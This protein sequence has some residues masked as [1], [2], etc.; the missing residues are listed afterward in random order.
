MFHIFYTTLFV[1]SFVLFVLLVSFFRERISIYYVLLFASILV[2]N[3]GYMQFCNAKDIGMAIYAN[4]TVYLGACFCPFFLMKCMADLC[5]MKVP[6]AFSM[7]LIFYSSIIFFFTMTIGESTLYY[8]N[9]TFVRQNGFSTLIKEY[10]PL[11]IL[12]PIYLIGVIEI[13]LFFIIRSFR[14]RKD[15]SYFTSVLLLISTGL[16]VGV[17]LFEKIVHLDVELIPVSYIISQI[18]V[19]LLLQRISLYDIS[20]LTA[21]SMVDSISFGFVL[22]DS[23]EKFL[24]GDVASKIW[25]P[26]INELQ[27]DVPIKTENTDFLQQIGKWVRGEDEREIVFFERNGCIIEAKHELIVEKKR[28]SIH[29]VYLRDDTKQ[30]EYTKLVEKYNENLERDVNE[31]AE[32]LDQMKD[33]II[34]SMASIVENRDNNT[35]G[36]ITRT[37]D[38]VK[39][40]VRHLQHERVYK[41]LTPEI[42]KCIIKAAPLHDFGKIAIPDVILNKPGKF[43]PEEYEGMKKH[44]A[45]GAVIVERILQ[46]SEDTT[47]K[48]IAV[49]LAH[50]HHEKWDG[51]GYPEGISKTSIPFEA[52]IMALADVFD[53]LVSKRVYKDSYGYD[54]AFSII[55]E[56]SG[57]HFDPQLCKEFLK[58]R[59]SFEKLYDSY[60]D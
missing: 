32:K 50:Y 16:S 45:K 6:K 7:G 30:Q 24:G 3:F 54:K 59:A 44:S 22:C 39:I 55:K 28:H 14:K 42:A 43:E 23:R 21:D 60:T 25:F 41:E 13:C 35:G 20:A 27:I 38:V 33:D 49:N 53:A 36:H 48:K 31:K 57:S 56:S 1:I 37:S 9:V 5:K 34:I 12:Y 26:E 10:G 51:S 15:V 52:R 11:H 8:K 4:Q 46:N 29:C 40:F 17:Y 2:T 18:G 19:L 58:C 47:F